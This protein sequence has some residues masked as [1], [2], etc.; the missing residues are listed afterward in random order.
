M[1]LLHDT[2]QRL[3]GLE[4]VDVVAVEIEAHFSLVGRADRANRTCQLAFRRYLLA[5]VMVL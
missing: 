2:L 3:D 4:L 1:S 5:V